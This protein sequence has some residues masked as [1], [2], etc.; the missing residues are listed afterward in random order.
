[1]KLLP[2]AFFDPSSSHVLGDP[3]VDEDD[4]SEGGQVVRKVGPRR[5]VPSEGQLI[6]FAQEM[7]DVSRRMKFLRPELPVP[8]WCCRPA[9]VPR[10]QA[11][12]KRTL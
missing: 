6:T 3:C 8:G 2:A 9:R 4:P 1:M 12:Q 10:G 7:H 5:R 11:R